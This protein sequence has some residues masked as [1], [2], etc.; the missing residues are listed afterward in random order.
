MKT[1]TGQGQERPAPR[2]ISAADSRMLICHF[3][4]RVKEIK[5]WEGRKRTKSLSRG[6]P[7]PSSYL[8]SRDIEGTEWNGPGLTGLTLQDLALGILQSLA[9]MG[10]RDQGQRRRKQH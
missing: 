3:G 4:S 6:S 1:N 8:H 5:G 10:S 9:A 2:L 7:F